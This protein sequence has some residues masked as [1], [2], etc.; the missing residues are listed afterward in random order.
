MDAKTDAAPAAT[1]SYCTEQ[2]GDDRWR[3]VLRSFFRGV[4]VNW[5]NDFPGP[6]W[7]GARAFADTRV[8]EMLGQRPVHVTCKRCPDAPDDTYDLV[9]QIAG[10]GRCRHAGRE[11]H[12]GPGDLL[13][14]DSARDFDVVHPTGYRFVAW[15]LPRA[16]LEPL[17]AAPDRA[18]ARRI[19][20]DAGPGRVLGHHVRALLTESAHL[21]S[22]TQRSL[23][24][25][26][27][28]LVAMT[29]GAA[30]AARESRRQT[31]RAVRQQQILTYIETHLHD[32]CLT[33]QRAA[34]DLSMSPRWLHALLA[35]SE[36]SFATRVTR[37]RLEECTRL[38]I[39]PA[40]SHLTIT[41][42]A[43]RSGF[44]NLSTFNR[45]FRAHYEMTPRDMRRQSIPIQARV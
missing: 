41:E 35:E 43:F 9:L 21:D 15:Q 22:I 17:L 16:I 34:R 20:G 19:A 23:V 30:P 33:A 11:T 31:L 10:R 28:G 13:L 27:C 3:D 36:M 7:F 18:A 2:V 4:G 37:R 32:P 38:L 39:D 26:L 14:F 40:F 6:S 29:L 12:W 24:T 1:L 8:L 42:I 44:D 45:R 25:H 5:L